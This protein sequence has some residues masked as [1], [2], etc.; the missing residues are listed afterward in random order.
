MYS[1]YMNKIYRVFIDE[2]GHLG[3]AERH[4]VIC[5]V[6]MD[7]SNWRKWG[8]ISNQ[9]LKNFNQKKNKDFAIVRNKGESP[10]V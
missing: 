8:K 1:A 3:R 10:G 9:L 2:S 5:C 7:K 4:M 6:V